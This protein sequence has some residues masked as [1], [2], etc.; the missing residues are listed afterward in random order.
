MIAIR[1][2]TPLL[3]LVALVGLGGCAIATGGPAPYVVGEGEQEL[4]RRPS[5]QPSRGPDIDHRAQQMRAGDTGHADALDP[6]RHMEVDAL[7]HRLGQPPHRRFGHGP[8]LDAAV[9]AFWDDEVA[10]AL[11]SAATRV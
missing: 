5:A 8:Q 9:G 7:R 10:P 3:A 4:A 6:V 11:S 1:S 2:M